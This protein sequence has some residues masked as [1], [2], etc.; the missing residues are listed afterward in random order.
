MLKCG[1]II[2]TSVLGGLAALIVVVS[3]AGD[4]ELAA[5]AGSSRVPVYS[6][7]ELQA[8]YAESARLDRQAQDSARFHAILDKVER[9]LQQAECGLAEAAEAVHAAALNHYPQYLESVRRSNEGPDDRARIAR[10]LIRCIEAGIQARAYSPETADVVR[11]LRQEL[12]AAPFAQ[13]RHGAG[14][15]ESEPAHSHPF[16]D[17]AKPPLSV[18][19]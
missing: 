9:K 2:L 5:S 10:N 17:F 8:L 4:P 15:T 19:G 6:A 13:P 14:S 3:W 18:D 11:K 16:Q 12:Q 1:N 7:S